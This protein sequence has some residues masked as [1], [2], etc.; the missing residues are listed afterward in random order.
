MG[1]SAHTEDLMKYAAAPSGAAAM[2][3]TSVGQKPVQP[4]QQD[5]D[6]RLLGREV[7]E[8]AALGD[9]GPPRDGIQRRGAFTHFD[10]QGFEGIEDGLAGDGFPGHASH[11]A[12]PARAFLNCTVQTV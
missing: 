2:A 10:E 1:V 4:F 9:A 12:C 11:H 8:Q 7:V 6:H 3:A 5:R